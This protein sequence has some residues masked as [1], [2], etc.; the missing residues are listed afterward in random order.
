MGSQYLMLK[1]CRSLLIVGFVSVHCIQGVADTQVIP[2]LEGESVWGGCVTDGRAMPFGKVTF[3]RD[4]YGKTGSNQ[5]QPLLIS[6]RGRCIWCEEPF[7]FSF[8]RKNLKLESEAG[9]FETGKQG[10]SLREVYRYV[11]RTFFPSTGEQPDELLFVKPQYNTWIEL[12]YDQ[13]EE[14]IRKYASDILANG[15]PAGVLMIDD[16]WQEDY[17]VW[18][19]HPGRFTDPKGP[20]PRPYTRRKPTVAPVLGP[21]ST[22]KTPSHLSLQ[23]LRELAA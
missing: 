19:F 8:D 10:D 1:T 17:G 23:K 2:L 22:R 21:L 18:E 20:Q 12:I 4:L 16:N 7:K 13:R 9:K 14:W 6:D 15:F 5:A 11:S 3:E